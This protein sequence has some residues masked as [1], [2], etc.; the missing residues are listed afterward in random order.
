MV[1]V[2]HWM[3][4]E[5]WRWRCYIKNT[6]HFCTCSQNLQGVCKIDSV[7]RLP[8]I[9]SFDWPVPDT[10]GDLMQVPRIPL[11]SGFSQ[12]SVGN[13]QVKKPQMGESL[14]LSG[15][16]VWVTHPKSWICTCSPDKV[17]GSP[18]TSPQLS[19]PNLSLQNERDHVHNDT[20]HSSQSLPIFHCNNPIHT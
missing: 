2:V 6:P 14:W 16:W 15:S 1:S 20:Q 18:C 4:V 3:D 10:R 19:F 11:R 17:S 13:K 8:L 5:S 7:L 9:W 12:S